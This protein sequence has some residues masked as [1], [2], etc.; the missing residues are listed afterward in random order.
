MSLKKETKVKKLV[1]VL[2]IAML[3]IVAKEDVVEIAEDSEIPGI[4]AK[5]S[6]DGENLRSNLT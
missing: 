1:L 6:K 2:A 5:A 3:V 4:T